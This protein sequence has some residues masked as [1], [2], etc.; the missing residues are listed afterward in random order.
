MNARDTARICT[1]AVLHTIS[2]VQCNYCVIAI[3]CI[4]LRYRSS[5][6][7]PKSCCARQDSDVQQNDHLQPKGRGQ[8]CH[9][10]VSWLEPT[11]PLQQSWLLQ[12][13]RAQG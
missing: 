6:P 11:S 13:V 8:L 10:H 9:A 12:R 4:M 1:P 5:P 3:I 2:G 7:V